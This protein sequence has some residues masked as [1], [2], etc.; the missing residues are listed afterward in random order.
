LIQQKVSLR[1]VPPALAVVAL[2]ALTGC[3][4]SSSPSA[5]PPSSTTTTLHQTLAQRYTQLVSDGDHRL[6]TLSKQLN[7]ANGNVVDIQS[8]F[9]KV[10]STYR[11]V[12]TSVQALP[13]PAAM[14]Q[15]VAAMVAALNAL[16]GDATQGAE[17]VTPAEFDLIFGKLAA[18]QKTEVAA[19]TKVNHDLGISSIN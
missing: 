15:D 4:G 9:K 18:D 2:L 6:Q 1:H 7:T 11:G 14:H 16:A 5:H 12:A 17:S 10:S 19:N 8:G 13:F 3:A